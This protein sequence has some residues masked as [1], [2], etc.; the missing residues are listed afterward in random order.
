ME[1]MGYTI[2]IEGKASRG[3]WFRCGTGAN[4]VYK[5]WAGGGTLREQY[6]NMKSQVCQAIFIASA[7]ITWLCIELL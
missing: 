3:V 4:E 5:Y 6:G 2:F 7:L 1:F